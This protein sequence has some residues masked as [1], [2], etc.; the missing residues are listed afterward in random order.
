MPTEM[1]YNQEAEKA[2][3]GCVMINPS[4]FDQVAITAGEFYLA[5]HQFI[6]TAFANLAR[7]GVA[8]DFVTLTDELERDGHLKEIGGAA[9]V[10]SLL[11]EVPSTLHADHYAKIVRDRARRRAMIITASGLAAAA[12]N[13]TA[14]LDT[15]AAQAIDAL[16]SG[17]TQGELLPISKAVS[18]VIDYVDERQ[19][20][21]KKIWGIPTGFADLDRL[22]GGMTGLWYIG[23]APGV[24]KSILMLQILIQ[25]AKRGCGSALFS[26]EM[27]SA[28][29]VI[30][31]VSG[32][33]KV[34]T[35]S[36]HTGSM[37]PD[38]LAQFYT[39]CGLLASLPIYI[40][41]TPSLSTAQLRSYLAQ[42]KMKYDIQLFGLDYLYLMSDGDTDK[43]V[44]RTETISRRIKGIQRSLGLAGL[45]V[46]SVTK[47][48]MNGADPES[49]NLRGS[50]QLVHDADIVMFLTK[51]KEATLH[52][53]SIT[54]ARDLDSTGSVE[55][56]K[57]QGWPAFKDV[58]M[59]DVQLTPQGNGYWWEKEK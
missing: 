29:Q 57:L 43:M 8:I 36:M 24:G 23:G 4:I 33:S 18:Q 31:A 56:V 30:R 21:P 1:P 12:Y 54:K 10:T 44:E 35:R 15:S 39:A 42:A 2:L 38:E 26:L 9:Y 14:D 7:R 47:G 22:T 13:D 27:S 25:A 58:A 53:L 11:T 16:S 41:D 34:P 3:L 32:E 59:H 55:L 46:N 17:S 51:E 49:A 28:A 6:W 52:K 5:R 45:T 50:G 48:G 37:T 40:C 20:N 19:Q